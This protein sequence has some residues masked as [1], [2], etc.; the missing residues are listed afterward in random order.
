[1]W[2]IMF[3]MPLCLLLI[4]IMLLISGLILWTGNKFMKALAVLDFVT[5]LIIILGGIL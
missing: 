2:N 1:M 4:F 5:L 3:S